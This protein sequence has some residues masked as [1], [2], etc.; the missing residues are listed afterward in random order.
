M[1]KMIR[2]I[3]SKESMS[4][5]EKWR[6]QDENRKSLSDSSNSYNSDSKITFMFRH[7][8]DN[9]E[10][11]ENIKMDEHYITLDCGTIRYSLWNANRWFAWLNRGKM[12][13]INKRKTIHEWEHKMPDKKL[14]LEFYDIIFYDLNVSN[15]MVPDDFRRIV[16]NSVSEKHQVWDALQHHDSSKTPTP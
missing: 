4:E 8:I 3:Y 9:A 11:I 5:K 6:R 13:D 12:V 1:F 2:S 15:D 10:H 14:L 7:L 16:T